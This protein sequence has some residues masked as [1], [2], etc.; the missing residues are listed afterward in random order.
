MWRCG[1]FGL[2]TAAAVLPSMGGVTLQ[3]ACLCIGIHGGR[4]TGH[5]ALK[6]R[7]GGT[8]HQGHTPATGPLVFLSSNFQAAVPTL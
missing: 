4:R 3:V 8:E 5:R 7:A 1:P 2:C 6:E